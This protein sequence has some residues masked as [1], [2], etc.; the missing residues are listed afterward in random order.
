VD[1][2]CLVVKSVESDPTCERNW[3]LHLQQN[4]ISNRIRQFSSNFEKIGIGSERQFINT[5]YSIF[6]NFSSVRVLFSW[7]A[8]CL[9]FFLVSF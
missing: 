6:Y 2:S 8:C 4:E 3:C 5:L 7:N 1:R 9:L